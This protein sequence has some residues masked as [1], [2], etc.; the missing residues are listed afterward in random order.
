[1]DILTHG[2]QAQPFACLATA[3][4]RRGGQSALPRFARNY[5][6]QSE[7]SEASATARPSLC[8]GS[9]GRRCARPAPEV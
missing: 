2:R 6:E 4:I 9:Q 5:F 1:M 8:K 7:R 3:P